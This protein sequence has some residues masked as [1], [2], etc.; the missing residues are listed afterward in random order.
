MLAAI[1]KIL[2]M[3]LGPVLRPVGRRIL[4]STLQEAADRGITEAGAETFRSETIKYLGLKIDALRAKA[5]KEGDY[6]A[7][8]MATWLGVAWH[9]NRLMAMGKGATWESAASF[10]PEVWSRVD[11]GNTSRFSG[12]HQL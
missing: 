11:P 9:S 1:C 10:P 2:W 12:E 3:I 7:N 8:R 4:W 5:P 6:I